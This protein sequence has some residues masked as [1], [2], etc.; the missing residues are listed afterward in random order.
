M[1]DIISELMGMD[2]AALAKKIGIDQKLADA[3][4]HL[5]ELN[6]LEGKARE[7][8]VDRLN[9]QFTPNV[10][11]DEW[12]YIASSAKREAKREQSGAEVM[13]DCCPSSLG[14]D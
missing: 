11:T 6:A 8:A 3:K 13:H 2:D 4:K 1:A 5:G 12:G 9:H 10:W 14:Y 7:I